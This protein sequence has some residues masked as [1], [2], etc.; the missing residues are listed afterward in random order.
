MMSLLDDLPHGAIVGIDSAPFIYLIEQ[1]ARYDPIVAPFFR[2]RIKP[3]QNQAVT[4]VSRA[5][6][7]VGRRAVE[8]HEPT[9][10]AQGGAKRP[11]VTARGARAVD[12]D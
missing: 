10:G 2:D 6:H 4:S 5:A 3:G 12:A 7:Q 8:Q 9:V 1:H 11:T